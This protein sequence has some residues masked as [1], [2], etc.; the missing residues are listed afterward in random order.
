MFSSRA[1]LA[2]GVTVAALT[3]S[4]PASAATYLFQLSGSRDATFTIDNSVTP[5][6]QSS[7]FIGNQVSYNNVAGSFGGIPGSAT[8]GF[9]T[10]LVATLNILGTPQGFTQFAG[11]DLF[12]LANNVPVFNIGT[13]NLTSI[14][15]GNSTLRISAAQAAAA[16]PEPASWM[17]LISGFGLI[18]ATLRRRKPLVSFA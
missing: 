11:P 9:G 16:V 18:G 6:F 5:D 8:V 17:M 14:G 4:V 10:F 2:A 12:T 13:F 7:S 3:V 15:S 1:F